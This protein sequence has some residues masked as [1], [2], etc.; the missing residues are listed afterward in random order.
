[1]GI[2]G[3]IVVYRKCKLCKKS[4]YV[5][6]HIGKDKILECKNFLFRCDHGHIYCDR[7]RDKCPKIHKP[8]LLN[9]NN[10]Y[11]RHDHTRIFGSHNIIQRAPSYKWQRIVDNWD[12]PKKEEEDFP[13]IEKCNDNVF[14][15]LIKIF[16]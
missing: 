15:K 8:I 3:Y 9:D 14:I 10:W 5:T 4:V 6:K 1:M 13:V 7:L 11:M 12:I 2:G 16:N